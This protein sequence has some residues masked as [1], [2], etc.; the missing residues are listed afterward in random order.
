[1]MPSKFSVLF[2]FLHTLIPLTCRADTLKPYLSA[3]WWILL[4][5]NPYANLRVVFFA[6]ME[7][8]A[9]DEDSLNSSEMYIYAHYY[10]CWS[11]N[12]V[13]V[14]NKSSRRS[15]KRSPSWFR[16]LKTSS[17]LALATDKLY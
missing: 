6:G 15:L 10:M 12:M 7:E 8:D 17:M 3:V 2:Y 5:I 11:T 9:K 1:M 14:I 16:H 4:S 13:I